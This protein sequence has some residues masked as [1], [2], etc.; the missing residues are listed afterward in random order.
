MR[1]SRVRKERAVR[2]AV[3][4]LCWASR[5]SSCTSHAVFVPSSTIR[6]TPEMRPDRQEQMTDDPV[7][8]VSNRLKQRSRTVTRRGWRKCP[9][10]CSGLC[11]VGRSR[12]SVPA[13]S[14]R[15]YTTFSRCAA[16]C[17][18]NSEAGGEQGCTA[19]GIDSALRILPAFNK[20]VPHRLPVRYSMRETP[21]R[22]QGHCSSH[23]ECIHRF[24]QR[25]VGCYP[26]SRR[27]VEGY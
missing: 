13:A 5:S 16:A 21:E 26:W 1:Q 20:R 3:S 14:R 6:R 2:G 27:F 15:C 7:A 4:L 22:V 9:A 17:A 10:R 19:S 25:I 11:R 23:H 24:V 18:A 12:S 8:G